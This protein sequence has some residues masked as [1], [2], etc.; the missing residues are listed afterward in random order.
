MNRRVK[1]EVEKEFTSDKK[2]ITEIENLLKS[3]QKEVPFDSNKFHNILVASTEAV[4]NAIQH[5]NRYNP[6]KKVI[7]KVIA[8][9]NKIIVSVADE[10]EGFDPSTLEDPRTPENILKE[11]GR[12]IFI[13]KELSDK[14][15]ITTSRNGTIIRMEF[16][17]R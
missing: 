17:I 11:R 10:G 12:G 9:T 15:S 2:V 4:M 14:T 6:R 16:K 3:I 8:E 7:F 13:I 5:G 1:L